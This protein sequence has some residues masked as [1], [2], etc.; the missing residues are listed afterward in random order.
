MDK[1]SNKNVLEFHRAEDEPNDATNIANA[2]IEKEKR[3][4]NGFDAELSQM[5]QASTPEVKIFVKKV[6][7]HYYSSRTPM[8]SDINWSDFVKEFYNSPILYRKIVNLFM[9]GVIIRLWNNDSTSFKNMLLV[10]RIGKTLNYN[11]CDTEKKEL[12]QISI[13]MQLAYSPS[14]SDEDDEDPAA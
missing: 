7:N 11:V 10:N 14:C 5:L 13:W 8:D 2:I 1:L 12:R 4:I 3:R 6:Q 9:P